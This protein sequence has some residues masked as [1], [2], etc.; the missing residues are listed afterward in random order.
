MI[1]SAASEGLNAQLTIAGYQKKTDDLDTSENMLFH[2]DFIPCS[3]RR[4]LY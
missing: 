2:L 1:V 4:I 3:E